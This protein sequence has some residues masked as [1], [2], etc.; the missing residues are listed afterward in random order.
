MASLGKNYKGSVK[1]DT[2]P[3]EP[4]KPVEKKESTPKKG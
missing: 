4:K 1:A 2:T 3:K